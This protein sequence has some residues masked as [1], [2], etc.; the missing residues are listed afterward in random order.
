MRGEY[1]FDLGYNL[2]QSTLLEDQCSLL[3]S[4]QRSV[5]RQYLQFAEA[6]E[7]HEFDREHIRRALEN[8]WAK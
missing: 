5:V 3:N 4:A 2:T 7:D 6:E 8:F 1:A